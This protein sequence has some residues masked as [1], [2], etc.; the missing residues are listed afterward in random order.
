MHPRISNDIRGDCRICPSSRRGISCRVP[1][2]STRPRTASDPHDAEPC[3]RPRSPSH[4]GRA[5]GSSDRADERPGISSLPSAT[6]R[7]IRAVLPSACHRSH[8]MPHV[9]R[10]ISFHEV[11]ASGIP[12][13]RRDVS[14]I[15]AMM[16]PSCS[17]KKARGTV[18]GLSALS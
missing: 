16:S 10:S 8:A 9:H 17:T 13:Q 11:R 15:Q 7:H 12:A 18:P 6:S 3:D 5:S 1:A 2:S 14:E 4:T